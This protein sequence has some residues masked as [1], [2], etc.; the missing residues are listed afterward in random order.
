MGAGQGRGEVVLQLRR[1]MGWR[2]A[3]RGVGRRTTGAH[4]I[5]NDGLRLGGVLVAQCAELL[6]RLVG[7]VHQR[8]GVIERW[9]LQHP[10]QHRHIVDRVT[11]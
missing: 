7:L 5:D 1:R 6:V 9:R 2:A 10:L 3:G 11:T 8:V 4:V